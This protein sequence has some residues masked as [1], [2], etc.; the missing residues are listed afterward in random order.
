METS[1]TVGTE[2][3]TARG[4]LAAAYRGK[5]LEDRTLLTHWWKVDA[6]KSLC[7]RVKEEKLADIGDAVDCPACLER[8]ATREKRAA[9]AAP[10]TPKTLTS[11]GL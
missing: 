10:R 4:V 6:P 5:A 11:E 9:A 1:K 8:M 2:S 3:F 7:G